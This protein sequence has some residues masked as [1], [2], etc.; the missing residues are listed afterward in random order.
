[1]ARITFQSE[2]DPNGSRLNSIFL[3]GKRIGKLLNGMTQSFDVSQGSHKLQVRKGFLRIIHSP[4]ISFSVSGSDEKM[5]SV[6]YSKF[7]KSIVSKILPIILGIL[8]IPV[9]INNSLL[10]DLTE[11]QRW[12]TGTLFLMLILLIYIYLIRKSVLKIEET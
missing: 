10:S 12:I 6:T 2:H 7:Y 1:M 9:I 11:N 3:D 4:E 8:F 5:Y